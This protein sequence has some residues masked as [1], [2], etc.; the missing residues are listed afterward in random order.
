LPLS[1][2]PFYLTLFDWPI[3]KAT[4]FLAYRKWF[5]SCTEAF[6]AHA[7]KILLNTLPVYDGQQ[8][9]P[10]ENF[11]ERLEVVRMMAQHWDVL[12]EITRKVEAERAHRAGNALQNHAR[13]MQ[14]Q[15]DFLAQR[16]YGRDEQVQPESSPTGY[17]GEC[18][19]PANCLCPKHNGRR[20]QTSI[21]EI[22][23]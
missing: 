8:T 11:A 23:G 17:T 12:D 18:I 16:G 7:F 14:S 10:I 2:N 20:A 21:E 1:T 6:Q 4:V 13:Q 22:F 3:R 5:P 19:D 9:E 15:S